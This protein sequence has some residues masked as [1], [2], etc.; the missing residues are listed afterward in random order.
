MTFEIQKDIVDLLSVSSEML[1]NNIGYISVSIF[2][3]KTYSQFTNA[4]N[5]LEDKGMNSLIIDLRGN[6]GGYLATVTQMISE[7]VDSKTV[8]YQMK[9][10]E[11]ISKYNAINNKTK[12][13]KVVILID[14]DSASASEIM[15]SAMQEQYSAVL[16]GKT[17]YGKGTVQETLDLSNNTMI[18]YTVQEWLTSKGN[19]INSVG[20][21]PNYDID[22]SEEYS[23]NPSRENDNQ[24][25]KAIELSK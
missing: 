25:Q 22:L 13:Y 17:T 9:T 2:G 16:V 14:N 1:D 15:A 12:G 21:K 6:S 18:K 10:R 24:L 7:F 8:I 23:K 3:E 5:S 4:L 20:I 19:S 11:G